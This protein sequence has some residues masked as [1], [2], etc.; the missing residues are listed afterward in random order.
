MDG[1]FRSSANAKKSL[2]NAGLRLTRLVH[3][4]SKKTVEQRNDRNGKLT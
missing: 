1:A 3:Y 2:V 4:L